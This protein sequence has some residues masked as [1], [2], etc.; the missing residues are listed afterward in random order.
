MSFKSPE[1]ESFGEYRERSSKFLAYLYPVENQDEVTGYLKELK[2]LHPRARHFCL[3]ARLIGRTDLEERIDDAGEPSGTA[4]RPILGVLKKHD[5]VNCL[6]IVVR[7]FG[8]TKLGKP[9]LINAYRE[10]AESAITAA[11]ITEKAAYIRYKLEIP[12]QFQATFLD[13]CSRHGLPVLKQ[14]Y[15]NTAKLTI[16]V[17]EKEEETWLKTLFREAF[18]AERASFEDYI[19]EFRITINKNTRIYI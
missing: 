19:E 11:S 6:C 7:Y 14:E 17:P 5:L 9:G 15:S 2:Q 13:S 12:Y 3:G 10:A 8:G 4:G 1:K 18:Q 16:A